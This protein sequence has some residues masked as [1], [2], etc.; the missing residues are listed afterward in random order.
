[1]C[2]W[3]STATRFTTT[4]AGHR[5]RKQRCG[6]AS[7]LPL[8]LLCW[9]IALPA[10][11]EVG[12]AAASRPESA[13]VDEAG[14]SPALL[15]RRSGDT[16]GPLWVSVEAATRPDGTLDWGVLGEEASKHFQTFAISPRIPYSV[17]EQSPGT[18][19]MSVVAE[20]TTPDGTT[21]VWYHYG[22]SSRD[23][24]MGQRWKSLQDLAEKA[25]AIYTGEVVGVSEGFFE[26]SPASLL[27]VKVEEVLRAADGHT[28]AR[29]VY[30]Y[31]PAARFSVGDLNFWKSNPAFPPRPRV[32]DMM[33]LADDRP[34]A[35]SEGLVV[36]PN[37][38]GVFIQPRVDQRLVFKGLAAASSKPA[39]DLD[40]LTAEVRALVQGRG[41][42]S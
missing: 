9:G 13:T 14:P 10:L 25:Q 17:L 34:P 1:M 26:G 18:R 42:G 5:L 27:T 22:W 40:A 6:L 30:L 35:D 2:T 39:P 4:D 36:L 3:T 29:E 24:P 8:A 38:D 16:D 12:G 21:E 23:M 20:R 37:P 28:S 31:Y 7:V 33:L 11:A 15:E 19:E 32:G 41:A